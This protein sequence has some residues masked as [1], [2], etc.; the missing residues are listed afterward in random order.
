MEKICRDNSQ[1]LNETVKYE[2]DV[3]DSCCDAFQM[4]FYTYKISMQV[5]LIVRKYKL[6]E[7]FS[8]ILSIKN[9]YF[10]CFEIKQPTFSMQVPIQ[11][12]PVH[13]E[14]VPHHQPLQHQPM[15]LYPFSYGYVPETRQTIHFFL[16]H[17]RL[18]VYVCAFNLLLM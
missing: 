5:V 3:F 7:F 17:L 1:S 8:I 2:F 16:F 12:Q 18:A 4:R 14:Q 9:L 13:R 10:L 15:L 11:V 6:N